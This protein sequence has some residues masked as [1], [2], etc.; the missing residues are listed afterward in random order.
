MIRFRN[1]PAS[2]DRRAIHWWAGSVGWAVVGRMIVPVAA[3][4][5]IA[6]IVNRPWVIPDNRRTIAADPNPAPWGAE[7]N[8]S[9]YEVERIKNIRILIVDDF[10]PWRRAV[11]SLL[12][13]SDNLQIVGEC[14]DGF[15]AVT[16]SNAL[17]PDLVLLDVQL[18]KMNGLMAARSIQRECPDRRILILSSYQCID[19][20]HEA[21]KV[22]D[23]FMVKAN[24]AREL[25]P[26]LVAVMAI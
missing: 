5:R 1:G 4:S 25:L 7:L 6:G 17:R 18:P 22:G 10:E 2:I 13:Q 14:S 15:E 21:L 8:N 24:A 19:I 23:G 20:I 16:Q 9:P 26:I 12:A 3:V 11:C